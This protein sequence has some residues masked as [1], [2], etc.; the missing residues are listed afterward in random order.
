M[1]LK[2]PGDHLLRNGFLGSPSTPYL[3][4]LLSHLEGLGGDLRICISNI[5]T[6]HRKSLLNKETIGKKYSQGEKGAIVMGEGEG[7]L[8]VGESLTLR[9]ARVSRGRQKGQL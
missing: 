9:S 2:L 7:G 6:K 4:T 3:P 5:K 1:V 8:A